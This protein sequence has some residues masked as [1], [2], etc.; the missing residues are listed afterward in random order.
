M[1]FDLEVTISGL[2]VIVLTTDKNEEKPCRPLAVDVLA[3]ESGEESGED[4]GGQHSGSDSG[5]DGHTMIH[6]P[7]LSFW[8]A[9]ANP[10]WTGADPYLHVGPRGEKQAFYGVTGQII[11]LKSN[12]EDRQCHVSWA[13]DGVHLPI[14]PN[15]EKLFDW[16]PSVESLGIIGGI[17]VPTDAADLP[18]GASARMILPAGELFARSVAVD[19]EGAPVAWRF[20]GDDDA[21]RAIA[22]EVVFRATA[23]ESLDLILSDTET[24]TR[25]EIEMLTNPNRTINIG[26]SNDLEKVTPDFV[27]SAIAELHHLTGLNRMA[28]VEGQT[29]KPPKAEGT[30]WGLSGKRSGVPL[31]DGV[32]FVNYVG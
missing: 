31:C 4:H 9:D 11:E 27:T 16:V 28:L 18:K 20:P 14:G 26:M 25:T 2:C 13:D 17:H 21:I 8:P 24:G 15:S 5:N 6:T 29:V 30:V 19:D 32:H 12:Y 3:V 23:I 1:A 7:R 10:D 22:N